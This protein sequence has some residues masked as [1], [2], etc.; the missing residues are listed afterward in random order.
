MSAKKKQSSPKTIVVEKS[1]LENMNIE[2]VLSQDDTKIIKV[3]ENL[4][5]EPSEEP[6]GI[7]F[8]IGDMYSFVNEYGGTGYWICA[9][10][11]YNK[12]RNDITPVGIISRRT[13]DY[14]DYMNKIEIGDHIF[15][16]S[17]K[18]LVV[19]TD[20]IEDNFIGN[21]LDEMRKFYDVMEKCKY[22]DLYKRISKQDKPVDNWVLGGVY[23]KEDKYG[24]QY[25]F[26]LQNIGAHISV[27][28][29]NIHKI[30]YGSFYKTNE[31]L[32]DLANGTLLFEGMLSWDYF[33]IID[34]IYHND[35]VM[36]LPKDVKTMLMK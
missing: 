26:A 14:P 8:N 22:Y 11:L 27:E 3:P 35:L 12:T 5:T 10:L 13:N 2:E 7:E 30:L 9:D 29:S 18:N 34:H 16:Y 23:S 31:F 28:M 19:K 1:K 21:F 15:Y 6:K 20:L 36:K 17:Q 24:T 33:K 25:I 32:N 4:L